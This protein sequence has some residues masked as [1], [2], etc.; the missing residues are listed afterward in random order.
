MAATAVTENSPK[1]SRRRPRR[2]IAAHEG[3]SKRDEERLLA[4]YAR[5]R[6][7][8]VLEELVDRFMPLAKSLAG[9]Y[10]GGVEP[11]DD[12]LQVASVGLVNALTRFDPDR[13]YSFATFAVPTILGE[14]RRHFRDRGWSIRVPRDLQERNL[15][16]EKAL[17]ELPTMLGR[18]PSAPEIADHLGISVEHVLEAMEAGTAHHARSIDA[19]QGDEG[20]D[21]G[22]SLADVLGADEAG[23]EA[24]EYGATIEPVLKRL[25]PRD[26]RILHMR[27]VEDRTQSDIAG[28]AGVSQMH[29]SRIL[30][31][32]LR[33]LRAAVAEPGEAAGPG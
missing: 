15:D 6:D 26:R 7:P 24:V 29:V 11:Y 9:R 21:D 2:P 22:R 4:E 27:F 1:L 12:L 25:S 13:G 5:T 16:V 30:R 10:S 8:A 17:S 20:E 23:Y 18:S 14:V 31:A 3:T 28:E 32:T 33:E 19:V